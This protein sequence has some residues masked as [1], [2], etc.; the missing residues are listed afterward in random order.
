M[1]EMIVKHFYDKRYLLND[2]CRLYMVFI[3][4]IITNCFHDCSPLVKV[5]N[6]EHIDN[7]EIPI[8]TTEL[9]IVMFFNVKHP[10]NALF[11]ITSISSSIDSVSNSENE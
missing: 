10:E 6:Q 4:C 8:D 11:S 5:S 7:A 3:K 2:V 9:G 1:R